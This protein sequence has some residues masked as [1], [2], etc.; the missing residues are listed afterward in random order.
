M[1]L[2]A[3]LVAEAGL[4][5]HGGERVLCRVEAALTHKAMIYQLP[6]AERRHCVLDL[7]HTAVL[8]TILYRLYKI[9]RFYIGGDINCCTPHS[10]LQSIAKLHPAGGDRAAATRAEM[11]GVKRATPILAGF[12]AGQVITWNHGS[13]KGCMSV[14]SPTD[15][16]PEHVQHGQS[17][18]NSTAGTN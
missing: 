6:V 5:A 17:A 18:L 1:R 10:T 2:C 3:H 13:P 14:F 4:V 7:R 11:Q 8:V 15:S 12:S 9:I 16:L